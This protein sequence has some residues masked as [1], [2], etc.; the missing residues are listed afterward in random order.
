MDPALLIPVAEPIPVHSA[1][2]SV[3]LITTLTAHLLFMN[4]LLGSAIIGLVHSARGNPPVLRAVGAKLPPLLALT[5]NMGVAPLLFLQVNYGHFDYVSSVLMG[6]W[7]FGVIFV[8]LYAYY[9][10]YICKFQFDAMGTKLRAAL[11]GTSILAVFYVGFMFSNNMTLML[12]PSA[13]KV[14]FSA[15]GG[16]LN[17]GD[18]TLYPRFLH[19][20]VGATAVGGLFVALLGRHKDNPEL[21][22]IGMT[23]FVRAT[24]VNL[25]LGLWFLIV[26]PDRVLLA[27][28]G[29]NIPA[30]LT[31]VAALVSAGIV[32]W[33]GLRKDPKNTAVWAGIT[34]F[35]M[36]CTRHWVRTLYLEPWFKITDIPVTNQYGSFYLFL[37]FFVVGGVL[38]AYMLK[39]YLKSV[40][41]RA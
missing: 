16:F 26:L 23:W 37:G 11:F 3:L 8:L 25:A 20:I 40:Q 31:L 12:E 2:F 38:V 10:F 33:S 6:G 13:W 29:Q 28:M 27:F 21:I 36:V 18:Q 14:Y 5:I 1:W 7:W 15:P 19:M 34:V 32:L 39:L 30:T 4:A 22:S 17:W 41:G 35:L 9:G 24:V